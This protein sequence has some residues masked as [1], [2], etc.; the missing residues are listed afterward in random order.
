MSNA[1]NFA[2]ADIDRRKRNK[3]VDKEEE[4]GKEMRKRERE[5]ASNQSILFLRAIVS[6]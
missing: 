5:I 1:S 6:I 2:K 3:K 4:E